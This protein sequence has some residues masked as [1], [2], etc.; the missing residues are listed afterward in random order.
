MTNGK[1]MHEDYL[2]RWKQAGDEAVTNVPSNPFANIAN[3]DIVY[4][5]SEILAEKGDHI[6]LRDIRLDYSLSKLLHNR[7]KIKDL[8]IYGYLNNVGILWRKNKLGLD[9]DYP[10]ASY[11]LSPRI[12][13]LGIKMSY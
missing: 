4:T 3:R 5:Q 8:S 1:G 10:S 6:R 9:P 7:F 13:S 2:N 12:F 11:Y